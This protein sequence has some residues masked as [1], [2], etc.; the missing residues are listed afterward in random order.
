[1]VG[2]VQ[3]AGDAE[4]WLPLSARQ[5]EQ[6]QRADE[7]LAAV[8]DWL[9]AGRRPSWPEVSAR[10]AE[11]KAYHSQWGCF[12]LH[13]GVVYRRWQEPRG[14]GDILQLLVPRVLQLVHGSVGAGHFGNSKTLHR[15]RGRFYWP[16][17]RRD[18]E[19]HAQAASG[20]RQKRGYDTRCRG[21]AF[22]HGDRVWVY[23]P[24]RKRGVC[25]KLRSH[26]QG[27]GEILGVVSKVVYRLRMPGRGR[28]VVLH[29][30]R[31]SPYRPLAPAV[32][33]EEGAGT[34]APPAPAGS[35]APDGAAGPAVATPGRIQRPT[36]RRRPPEHLRD[37]VSGEGAVG[38]D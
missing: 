27:P 24:V 37:Y 13:D 10:G 34:G 31:L 19:L 5:L 38:D 11:V 33:E 16:G 18:V 17:C 36:R 22:I 21:R 32:A 28:V 12:Q 23:C 35:P 20:V 30:D 3:T 9:E 6:Q 1:M 29:R 8:R 2:A 7:T 15:L 25:P 14:K 4:G 26:W